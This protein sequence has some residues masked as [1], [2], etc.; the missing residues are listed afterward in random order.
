MQPEESTLLNDNTKYKIV[1]LGESSV[2]KS[3]IAQ[4]IVHGSFVALHEV[5]FYLFSQLYIWIPLR[6][7]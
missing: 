5:K 4:Y 1:F 6:K 3:S 2:G 7:I